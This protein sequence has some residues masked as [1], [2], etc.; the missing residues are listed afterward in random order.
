MARKVPLRKFKVMLHG[1]NLL[2]KLEKVDKHGVYIIR[3]V[4]AADDVSAVQTA[5]DNFWSDPKG[6]GLRE[7]LLNRP[8][9][10]PI[11]EA[12]EVTEV[13]SFPSSTKPIGLIFYPEAGDDDEV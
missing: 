2:L 12:E 10:P 6:K 3:F 13:E 8:D 7:H 4:G 1:R 11:F 9:D 5:L